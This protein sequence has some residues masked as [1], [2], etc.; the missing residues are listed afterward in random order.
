[1]GYARDQV[2]LVPRQEGILAQTSLMGQRL[3]QA[4]KNPQ[5]GKAAMDETLV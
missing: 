5:S 4:P 2:L 1:M 3:R